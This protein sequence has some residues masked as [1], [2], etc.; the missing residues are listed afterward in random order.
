MGKIKCAAAISHVFEPHR[1]E[2]GAIAGALERRKTLFQNTKARLCLRSH[3]S[4]SSASSASA[5]MPLSSI[6]AVMSSMP[7][8]SVGNIC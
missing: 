1:G 4:S 7:N 2:D 6:A 3:W 8:A 5:N